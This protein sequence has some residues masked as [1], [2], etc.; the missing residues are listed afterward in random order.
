M[1]TTKTDALTVRH[2]AAAGVT[3]RQE[4]GAQQLTRQAETAST[5]AAA[6]AEALVKAHTI[7]ALQRPRDWD[8][9]RVRVLDFCRHPEF[10]RIGDAKN[11]NPGGAT[12]RKPVGVG[13][14]G[15]SIRFVEAV[16]VMMGNVTSRVVPIFD[17]EDRRIYEVTLTDLEA[18]MCLSECFIVPKT[19]Q[20]RKLIRGRELV[21]QRPNSYGDMVYEYRAAGEDEIADRIGAMQSKTIRRLGLRMIPGW[22]QMDAKARLA[23]TR[24]SA[25]AADPAAARKVIADA[26]AGLGVKPSDLKRYLGADLGQASPAQLDE[27]RGVWQGITDGEATWADVLE[28]RLVQ[29]GESPAEPRPTKQSERIAATQS[30]REAA[31]REAAAKPRKTSKSKARKRTAKKTEPATAADVPPGFDDDELV[32]EGCG[33]PIESGTKCEPCEVG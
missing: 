15:L 6:T 4:F 23:A 22:L 5:A 33:V 19:V 11:P 24:A 8:D 16:L 26:F 17:D 27:L 9:V 13:I 2:A 21:A 29:R 25:T 7:M 30:K 32:C 31:K 10:A 18:N 1:P 28:H 12:Y 3:Q 20:R 14:E